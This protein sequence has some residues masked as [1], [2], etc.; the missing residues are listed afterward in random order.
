MGEVRNAFKFGR[1]IS[2]EEGKVISLRRAVISE[3]MLRDLEW[4]WGLMI[5]SNGG[6]F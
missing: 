2:S 3:Q 4:R 5:V 1:K 6:L